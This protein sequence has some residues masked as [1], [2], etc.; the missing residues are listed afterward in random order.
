MLDTI[1]NKVKDEVLDEIGDGV[2]DIF[3]DIL[4]YI[5]IGIFLLIVAGIAWVAINGTDVFGMIF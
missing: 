5:G 4:A 1:L 3:E 2:E